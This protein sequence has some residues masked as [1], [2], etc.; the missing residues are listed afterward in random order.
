[1]SKIV[2]VA[3]ASCSF[4]SLLCLTLANKGYFVYA[5]YNS[6]LFPKNISD[7]IFPVKLDVRSDATCVRTVRKIVKEKKRIDAVINLVGVSR[8]GPLEKFSTWDFLTLLDIN[9]AGA[10]RLMKT[11]MP[12][13]PKFGRVIN[14]GS[15]C[16]NIAFPN[17]SL[18]SASKAALRAMTLAAYLE[19]LP[20]KKYVTLVS[21]GGI[22]PAMPQKMAS[23][24]ARKRI[25]LINWLLP[26][27]SHRHVVEKIIHVLEDEN[28]PPEVLVGRDTTFLILLQRLLPSRVWNAIQGYVW[29]RQQ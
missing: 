23:T 19:W 4:G 8:S 27:V 24:S 7:S 20:K 11:A 28:P 18:Y 12:F 21:P 15:I 6:H 1:M 16:G 22:S 3:G 5:G 13:I 9:A 2:L 14:V 25:P 10:F 26:L 17:F 29:Q